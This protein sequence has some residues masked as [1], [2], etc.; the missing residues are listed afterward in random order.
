MK[1]QEGPTENLE[2]T[3][4][5]P[6]DPIE[7][8]NSPLSQK[9]RDSISKRIQTTWDRYIDAI[10]RFIA[11]N[12]SV[13]VGV[14]A[15]VSFVPKLRGRGD[16]VIPL[17]HKG[18]FFG[19][20]VLLVFSLMLEVALRIWAQQFMEYEVLQ[21]REEIEKYF[22]ERIHYT[23]S[24]RLEHYGWQF[25]VVRRVTIIAPII[26]AAGLILSLVFLYKNLW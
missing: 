16:A 3:A 4:T 9:A 10:H 21:P 25:W 15:V 24:Y 13:I 22:G 1:T 6:P 14:A 8:Q 20:L 11:L 5:K 7:S 2:S 23:I 19:G 12:V 26:F 18:Y 17:E